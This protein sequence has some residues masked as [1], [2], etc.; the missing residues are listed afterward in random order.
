MW[1]ITVGTAVLLLDIPPFQ[2]NA[3]TIR[4]TRITPR[5]G[6]SDLHHAQSYVSSRKT[7]PG[8]LCV[9]S[10]DALEDALC[11]PNGTDT[12]AHATFYASGI[13]GLIRN[14]R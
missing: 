14:R 11:T 1:L 9:G 6:K 3:Q 13:V 4:F 7:D 5:L 10:E 2:Y 8:A 12:L